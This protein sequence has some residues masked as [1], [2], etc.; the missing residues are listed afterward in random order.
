MKTMKSRISP[1]LFQP[2]LKES[3]SLMT[4]V[5]AADL[6]HFWMKGIKIVLS[7]LIITIL[8]GLTGGDFEYFSTSQRSL[9]IP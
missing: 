8:L 5:L 9:V 4:Q 3:S 2:S 6:T 7:F 1:N